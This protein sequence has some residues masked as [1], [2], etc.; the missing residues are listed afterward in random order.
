MPTAQECLAM[1]GCIGPGTAAK[2]AEICAVAVLAGELSIVGAMASGAFA[3]AHAAG[4]R[5][6]RTSPDGAA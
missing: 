2:L 4:G 3:G 5:K 6:G 1:L